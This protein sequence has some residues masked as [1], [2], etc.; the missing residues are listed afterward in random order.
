MVD[1]KLKVGDRIRI[2][3]VPGEGVAGYWMHRDTRRVFKK[4]I[5]RNRTVRIFKFDEYG[6]PWYE[7]RF[8]RR[9]GRFEIHWLNVSDDEDNW[10]LVQTRNTRSDRTRG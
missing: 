2:V 1:R 3:S 8:K 4:L 10:V 5:A 7:C 9:N 6:M